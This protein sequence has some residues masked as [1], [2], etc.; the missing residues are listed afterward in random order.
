MISLNEKLSG[1]KLSGIRGYTNLAKNTPGCI[2]L[3][4]GEPDF[5][6]PQAIRDAAVRALERGQTH[7]A[8]NQG[9][10]E[11]RTA[12]AEYETARGYACDE[13]RILITSGATGALFTAL[14]GILNPED[15]VIVPTPAFPLYQSIATVAGAKTVPLDVTKTGFQ[16]T[17]EDLDRVI[18]PKTRAIVLNSP[19]NPT[20]VTFTRES[21]EIVKSAVL[22]KDIFLICD[23]VYDRLATAPVP[24]LSTDRELE[25]QVLLCQ[26]FSKPYAMTG[27]RV[28]YLAGPKVVMERMLLLHAAQNASVAT[29][30]QWACIEALKTD[31]TPMAESYAQ[32]QSY[33]CG[34]LKK[35]GLPFPEPGG[36]FY[37]FADIT[38][39]GMDSDTFCTRLIREG[40]VATVPGICFGAEGYIRISCACDQKALETAMDRLEAFLQRG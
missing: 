7:Y 1:L 17:R 3:T 20:G 12:I 30:L 22:G 19:N 4:I 27:W 37:V 18:T 25:D 39:T 15:E 40:G 24:D 33:V 29:F 16:I 34:R 13:S 26:S 23:N 38:G 9:L 2:M 11:L 21:L 5:D 36:S 10:M 32:R 31:I 14:L 28:G 8:P 35:M 6:T